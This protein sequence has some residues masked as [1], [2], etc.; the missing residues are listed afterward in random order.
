MDGVNDR[1]QLSRLERVY[2][3][4]RAEALMREGVTVLDPARLDIR[5]QADVASDVTLDVNVILEGRVSIGP[6][7]RIGAHCVI[8]DADLGAGVVVEPHSIIDGATVGDHCQVGPSRA[9]ARAPSWPPRPRSATSWKPRSP[10]S[11]K[12]PR[13]II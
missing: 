3:G 4:V 2:Q 7:C 1:V 9:C 8:R 5:G 12:G 11:A 6:G 13:S 10:P